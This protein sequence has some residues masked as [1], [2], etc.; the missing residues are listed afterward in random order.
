MGFV[1]SMVGFIGCVCKLV[2]YEM[3]QCVGSISAILVVGCILWSMGYGCYD[4][5]IFMLFEGEWL[6]LWLTIKMVV[7]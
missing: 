1:C 3:D 6:S 2:R 4:V 5:D 7:L